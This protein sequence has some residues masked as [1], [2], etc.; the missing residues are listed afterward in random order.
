MA[1]SPTS[2]QRRQSFQLSLYKIYRFLDLQLTAGVNAF[3]VLKGLP[4]AIHQPL[5]LQDFQRFSARL[6]LTQDLD[7]ALDELQAAF[8]GPDMNLLAPNCA[9][10]CRPV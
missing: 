5:I 7:R 6:E 1:G 9:T 3:D 4:E 10:A 2:P 8:A